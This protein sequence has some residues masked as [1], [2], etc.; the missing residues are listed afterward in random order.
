MEKFSC[1]LCSATLH[2]AVSYCVLGERKKTTVD[3]GTSVLDVEREVMRLDTEHFLTRLKITNTSGTIVKLL[4]AYPVM[5]D[6]FVIEGK[7][8]PGWMV[9]NGSRQLNDVPATCMLGE[10]NASFEECVNRLSDEG[11]NIKD[12]RYGDSVLYGDGIT[13]IKAGKQYVA[14]EILTCNNQ[15]TD[16]SISSDCNG[17]VKAIRMG[18]EFNC[19]MED[20]DTKYTDWVRISC[21]GNFTRLVE[22]YSMHKKEMSSYTK[23]DSIKP[24]IYEINEAFT[25]DAI[26]EKLAFLRGVRAPFEYI[27]IG[28]GWQSAVGDWEPAFGININQQIYPPL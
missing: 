28:N 19:L 26:V 11:I 22:E 1:G 3:Y 15:L 13:V 27:E 7:P 8:T 10:K 16:I 14:L 4:S 9:Y 5:T 25:H 18:G 24:A 17:E 23:S 20:G 2:F 21:G 6:D 12:Y